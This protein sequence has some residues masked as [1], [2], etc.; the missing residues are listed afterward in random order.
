MKI[1]IF[2]H[3]GSIHGAETVLYDLICG[4]SQH[5]KEDELNLVMP[6]D[7][8]NDLDEILDR[9][10]INIRRK[11]FRFRVIRST[12]FPFLR[13]TIYGLLF[14]FIPMRRYMKRENF[15]V[16]YINTIVNF[17]PLLAAYCSGKRYVVHTHEQS[18]PQYR[19][20][21]RW[22]MF[23][24]RKLLCSPRCTNIFVSNMTYEVWREELK[25]SEIPNSHII[26][27]QYD[28]VPRQSSDKKRKFTF[29]FI[30]SLTARKNTELLITQFLKLDGEAKLV[31]AGGGDLSEGLMAKYASPDVVF[32]GH[33]SDKAAFYNSIDA[34][35]LPSKNESWGLVI[36]EAMS[37]GV[38]VISTNKTG[39]VEVFE[40]TKECLFFDP[41]D[42]DTLLRYMQQ[43][44]DDE[45]LRNS[46]IE[47]SRLKLESLS[48]NKNFITQI[49]NIVN[50]G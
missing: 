20:I 42:S 43:I 26:Y 17:I 1:G 12:L 37:A 10:K 28:E 41:S 2:S 14:G 49:Y 22:F 45:S 30:G 32:L 31:L 6:N 34:L 11:R 38:P 27:S 15:D 18:N 33:I 23:A 13:N 19:Y 46:L 7:G 8:N 35:V 36:M 16:I 39:I 48:V 9:K 5:H 44:K 47:A 25:L 4:L 50:N 3:T 40:H 29:G 24:Y 21:P